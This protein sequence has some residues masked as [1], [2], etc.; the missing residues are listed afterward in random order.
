[1]FNFN[2]SLFIGSFLR[3]LMMAEAGCKSEPLVGLGIWVEHL[4]VKN[5]FWRVL[6]KS[7]AATST[8]ASSCR[9]DVALFITSPLSG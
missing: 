9:F 3:L 7:L 6:Q 2:Y 5:A 8:L 1:M 4:D